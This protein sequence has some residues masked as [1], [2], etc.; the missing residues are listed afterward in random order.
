MRHADTLESFSGAFLSLGRTH[1]AIGQ[2]EFNVLVNRKVADQVETLENEPD[3]PVS[4]PRSFRKRKVFDG[5]VIENVLTVGRRI[6]QTENREK[7]R[8][9]AARGSGNGNIF[10]LFNVQVNTGECV[11]FDLVCVE[12]LLYIREVNQGPVRTHHSLLTKIVC[13]RSN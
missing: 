6:E 3:F 13:T 1:S 9:A 8:L 7:S 11:C 5:M 10:T 12:N 2:R 4:D